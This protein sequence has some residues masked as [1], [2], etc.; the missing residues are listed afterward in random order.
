M[1]LAL[2]LALYSHIRVLEES[3]TY[4]ENVWF[5]LTIFTRRGRVSALADERTA[6]AKTVREIV[7]VLVKEKTMMEELKALLSTSSSSSSSSA[8]ASAPSSSSSKTETQAE[9][10]EIGDTRPDEQGF[11]TTMRKR[12]YSRTDMLSM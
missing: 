3:R 11:L 8:S 12:N 10:E 2:P 7:N 4:M 5:L 1:A 9:R 6:L